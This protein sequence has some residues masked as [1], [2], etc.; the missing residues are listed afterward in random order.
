MLLKDGSA[1]VK[2]V[3]KFLDA[4]TMSALLFMLAGW[5]MHLPSLVAATVAGLSTVHVMPGRFFSSAA[6]RS[7]RRESYLA[8]LSA[9]GAGSLRTWG[10]AGFRR[11]SAGYRT[12]DRDYGTKCQKSCQYWP[13]MTRSAIHFLPA[14]FSH[15]RRALTE[16]FHGCVTSEH[17]Q[18]T[19]RPRSESPQDVR[20]DRPK[21]RRM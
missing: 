7:T 19:P 16:C 12:G 18:N 17:G 1:A 8:K 14:F 20:E 5:K 13:C 2:R 4:S 15:R 10:A 21:S 3:A 11:G 6:T 9:I